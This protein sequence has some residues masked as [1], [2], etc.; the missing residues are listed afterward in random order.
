MADKSVCHRH[1]ND[2]T[3]CVYPEPCSGTGV[4]REENRT[5][6]TTLW[7]ITAKRKLAE[8]HSIDPNTLHRDR[9]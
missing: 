5:K 4:N 7:D 1:K 9:T 3:G 6:H 2:G 8:L